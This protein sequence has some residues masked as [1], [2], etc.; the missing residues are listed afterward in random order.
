M[1]LKQSVQGGVWRGLAAAESLFRNRDVSLTD[2]RNFLLL[3]YPAALGTAIHATPLIPAL[4]QAV[5]G[6][7][8]AVVASGFAV[9]VFRGN[10]GV[11][12]LIETPN[13]VKD[14]K[15]AIQ[16]LRRQKPFGAESFVTI[17]STGGERTKVALA[18]MLSGA[19]DRVGFTVVP[20]SYR[21]ALQFDHSMSQIANNLRI[22]DALGYETRHF[23]P[24]IF[25]SELDKAEAQR[26]LALS[27]FDGGKPIAIFVT[28][29]SVTQR[30]SWRTDRF[31]AAARFLHET[32]GA[33]IVFVGTATESAA[34]EQLRNGLEFP[35]L[36]VA[37]QTKLPV[38]AAIMSLGTVGL[39]LDTGPMHIGRAVGLPMVIVAP[40]W[41]PPVEWL[42]IGDERFHIL[43]N[44]DMPTATP[45]YVIDEV[46]VDEVV[47]GLTDLMTRYSTL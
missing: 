23:E 11:D 18:A 14:L 12:R 22:V 20:E 44:A 34:I 29:T 42:P 45:D 10:P 38:L 3:Q 5:P 6:C 46:N 37:G 9:D 24:Q 7:G 40:A 13:P 30:K 17:T 2:A 21:V 32:C 28:Q 25:F 16:G 27:G 39:S 36:S 1:S 4:R 31:Q 26:L 15:G 19:T 33:E 47:V 8:I 43:K 35:T 41:S